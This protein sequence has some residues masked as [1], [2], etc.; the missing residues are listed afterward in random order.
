LLVKGLSGVS[1]D[2][3]SQ[4]H[5]TFGAGGVSRDQPVSM[6]PELCDM[7]LSRVRFGNSFA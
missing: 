6:Q 2:C 7:T 1:R 4:K 3:S 5:R